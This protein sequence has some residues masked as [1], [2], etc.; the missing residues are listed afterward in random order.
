MQS[1]VEG[2]LSESE[3]SIGNRVSIAHHIS[4]R[5]THDTSWLCH[6]L[7]DHAH[8]NLLSMVKLCFLNGLF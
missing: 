5:N 3:N 8:G 2:A 7:R 6:N 1:M 4:T